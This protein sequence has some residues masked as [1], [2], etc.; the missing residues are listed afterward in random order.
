M[1][2]GATLKLKDQFTNTLLKARKSTDKITSSMRTTQKITGELQKSTSALGTQM[3]IYRNELKE[4]LTRLD[5]TGDSMAKLKAKSDSYNKQL[6]IQRQILSSL[7]DRYKQ[8]AEAEG[9]NSRQALRL[10]NSIAKAKA[11][12]ARIEKQINQTNKAI[13]EQSSSWQRLKKNFSEAYGNAKPGNIFE[14][15]QGAGTKVTGLG[16]AGAV[17]LGAMVKTAADFESAMSRVAAL[18]GANDEELQK[19]RKTAEELG[20]TT[21]F[22]ATQAAEGMQFLSMAGFKTNEIIAAMPGMLDMAAAAQMDLGRAADISSNILSAFGLEASE[23]GR[24]ADVLTKAFTSSNVDLEMLGYTMKYVGPI[25]KAAGLSL[26]EMSAAAGILGNAGIQA[27]QAG[28]T[29]RATILRLVKPPKQTAEALKMLGVKTTD[30]S[31]KM[32][33][34]ADIIGQ[35]QKSTQGMT[36]AQKTALAAQIAGTEAASGFIE[37]LKS[38]PDALKKF[39]KELENSGGT[40]GRIA[41]KQ[42]DN[43]NGSLTKLRSATEGAA[44]SIGSTLSPY[45]RQAAEFLNGLVDRFNNLSP[46]MKKTIAITAAVATGIALIGGPAL[47]LIGF[48]PSIAAGFSMLLGPIG[49]VMVA[50]AGLVTAG[51]YLYKNWDTIKGKAGALWL[52][53]KNIFK[54]GVN[55]VIDLLNSIIEK[56]NLIPGI[57]IGK[58]PK[59]AITPTTST[60]SPMA[61]GHAAGLAYVPY[62]NYPALLHRG[63]RVLTAA[64]NRQYS[65]TK[66]QINITIP[67]LADRIDVN[68]PNDID[69]L[70]DRLEERLLQTSANMG[71]A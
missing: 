66:P 11:E 5:D 9:E 65:G 60:Y 49:L 13:K 20:R 52:A 14:A 41:Q 36:E 70:L 57:E 32:L 61:H 26:E 30:A 51:I 38:G 7:K 59:M 22:S 18:S 69:T 29:L 64:E 35:I 42:L 44:I 27:E 58:I 40:S 4:T 28:T 54:M 67:K 31:G 63:E 56:I 1:I 45:I 6:I 25:A 39:T 3:Q 47:L 19:M 37:L 48:L 34:L 33:P 2:L 8:V 46:E 53:L 68:N 55:Y 50:I 71:T 16:V 23:M 62:D 12:E 43:L 10:A 21:A 17:G 15:M 24:V